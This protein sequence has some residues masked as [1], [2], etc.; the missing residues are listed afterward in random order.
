MKP[1]RLS[2]AAVAASVVLLALSAARCDRAATATTPP[3]RP[4]PPPIAVRTEAARSLTV[5]ELLEA[6]GTLLAHESAA[7]AAERDGRVVGIPVERG[8]FV[9]AG[10]PIAVLENREAKATVSDAEASLAWT[11]SEVDRY[12]GLREKGVISKA[13]LQRKSLDLQSAQARLDLARKA[14]EDT[15]IRAPFS[16]IVSE[17][18]VSAGAFVRRGEPVATLVQVDPIRAE[19]AIPE[20]AATAVKK[21]QKIALSVQSFPGREF[22]G[23]IA[24]VGPSL[25]SEA[26]T[27]VVEAL[28]PNPGRLLQPGLFA[29]ARIEMPRSGPAVFVPKAAIVTDAGVS[30]VFVVGSAAVTER[31]VS[32]GEARGADVEVRSGVKAGE[33]VAVSPDRRLADGLAVAR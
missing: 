9:A 2:L 14:L 17:R 27:L 30:R 25:K 32:V 33:R 22:E 1:L 23:E 21:G 16:G 5:P 24:Y 31:I 26:R 8:S 10:A 3:A 6:T 13:D 20:S 4:T 28:V 11:Q 12:A 29:R 18:R 19:L 7:V 15:I